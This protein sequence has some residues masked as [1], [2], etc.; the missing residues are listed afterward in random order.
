MRCK[1][2]I[3]LCLGVLALA[4]P[5]FAQWNE[6]VLYSFQ[7]GTDGAD[8]IGRIVADR[9]GNLYGATVQGGSSSCAGPAQ[10]GT[11]YELSPPGQN[12]QPWI[13]TVLHVF[14]GRA[15]GDG[16]TPGGG[17]VMDGAGNLYGTTAYNGTGPCM[18]LGAVVG[19][20]TV[21]ELSPPS[22]LGGSWTESVLYNFQG[23]SDGFAPDGDLVFDKAGNLYGATL[24]GGG[25]GTNCGDLLY[26]NCGTIFELSPPTTKG[27]VWAEN[28]LYSF[29]GLEPWSIPGDGSE[30]NGGLVFD[31][32]GDIFGTTAYGGT[33][34]G[35]CQP[36]G[37]GTAFELAPPRQEGGAWT[38][39]VVHRFLAQPSDGASP[40][41]NLVVTN[42]A[43]YGTTRSGGTHEEGVIFE[44]EP[45]SNGSWTESLIHIFADGSD[46]VSPS[47]LIF[48]PSGT[49]YGAADGPTGQT[50]VIF[51]ME[52]PIQKEGIWNLV[53]V[54]DFDGPANGMDPMDLSLVKGRGEIYGSTLYGG[55][56]Q[57]CGISGCGVVFGV[58]P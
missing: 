50:G 48:G 33:P 6:Q 35:I 53:P 8:P 11:V 43:L 55:A 46:G 49:F 51:Q 13:E 37:C 57:N 4:S 29:G 45:S 32:A 38:E 21:Y 7:G 34:A 12:G 42:G 56:G 3:C 36:N 17:L 25:R 5:S 26:P 10:C 23:G 18:V 15:L 16:G 39:N 54:Y 14:K 52:P 19:C 22:Q 27:G 1:V 9:H 30:P 31:E 44:L 2:C 40:N 41:G 47:S 58:W 20:G 24:F 28:V